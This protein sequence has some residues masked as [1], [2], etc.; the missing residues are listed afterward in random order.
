MKSDLDLPSIKTHYAGQLEDA[1]WSRTGEGQDG[2]QAWGTWAFL[3]NEDRQ[4][5]AA[6]TVLHLPKTPRRYLLNL[7]ADR[8]STP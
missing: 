6:F 1:G 7:R 3:V 8:T 2:P 5:E 4:W